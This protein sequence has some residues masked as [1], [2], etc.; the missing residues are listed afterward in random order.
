VWRTIRYAAKIS[1]AIDDWE[2]QVVHAFF[3][4]PEGAAAALALGLGSTIPLVTS[5]LGHDI[6]VEPNLGY[7]LRLNPYVSQMITYAL[8]RSARIIAGSQSLSQEASKI[9]GNGGKVVTIP[10]G[11]DCKKFRPRAVSRAIRKRFGLSRSK[12]VLTIRRLSP[13]YGI[14][15]LITAFS[16]V[17]SRLNAKLILGGNGPLLGEALALSKGLGLS[18]LLLLGAVPRSRVPQLMASC[19]V[20]CDPCLL[21]QGVSTLEAMASGKPVVGFDT[22]TTKVIHGRTGLLVRPGDTHALAEALEALLRDASR[23]RRMGEAGRRLVERHY[24]LDRN[25]RKALRVY[26]QARRG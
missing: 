8:E 13:E 22:F 21:G 15:Q 12:A 1:Q 16:S 23:T 5:V 11:V 18:K 7:G 20:Y 26:S 6:D 14:K 19:D 4:Y 9:L 10:P 25:V 3:A 24:D 17:A 2:P